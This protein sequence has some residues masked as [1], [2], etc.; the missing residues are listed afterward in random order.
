MTHASCLRGRIFLEDAM[1]SEKNIKLLEELK[2]KLQE[3]EGFV[4]TEYRGLTVAEITELRRKLREAE[5]EYRVAKNRIFNLALKELGYPEMTDYLKGPTAIAFIKE[6]VVKASKALVDFAKENEALVIKAGY[7]DGQVVD[8]EKIKAISKLPSREELI[9]KLLGSLKS[10]LY[11]LANV[12]N[13][14]VRGL[15]VALSEIAKQKEAQPA[16]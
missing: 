13:G 12:L 15:A 14:P 6:D 4:L 16:G 5:T 11:G 7:V 1:P 2:A 10:P 9:A 3:S 8:A